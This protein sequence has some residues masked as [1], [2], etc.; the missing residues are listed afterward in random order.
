M[1]GSMYFKNISVVFYS[2]FFLLFL[3]LLILGI[4]NLFAQRKSL[5]LI[6]IKYAAITF[7]VFIIGVWGLVAFV[8]QTLGIGIGGDI[9]T[10]G[11]P[12]SASMSSSLSS[13]YNSERAD[14]TT[15]TVRDTREFNKV[16]Y[17][18]DIK[19]REVED[20]SKKVNSLI[21]VA[22]GR[23]D[24]SSV[25]QEYASFSFV[26]PKSNFESFENDIS[27]LVSQKLYVKHISQQN[28]LNQ[29]QTIESQQKDN[30]TQVS[31]VQKQKTD[32]TASHTKTIA[33]FNFY[34][35]QAKKGL[36]ATN[37]RLAVA[38]DTNEISDL[39]TQRTNFSNTITN[40][41]NNIYS[42]NSNYKMSLDAY[43]A[44]I[45]SLNKTKDSLATQTVDLIDQVETVQGSISIRYVS[46]WQ[47][48]NIYSPISPALVI[49]ILVVVALIYLIV[50][51]IKAARTNPTDPVADQLEVGNR[52]YYLWYIGVVIILFL[53]SAAIGNTYSNYN[54]YNGYIRVPAVPV[55]ARV[56]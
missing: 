25:N 12:T 52:Y 19:T 34:L 6:F 48:V 7:F 41:N 55:N 43:N 39:Y 3:I 9:M 10:P 11:I 22:G 31:D 33:S 14:Y 4:V 18:G 27:A 29:K 28:L 37:A 54:R 56:Y 26:V 23:V 36:A 21:H 16:S 2:S 51:T 47:L 32:L 35:S 24:S 8:S 45:D 40:Y 17:S 20:V 53:L 49:T 15:N 5:G 30:A 13:G 1:N 42:E 46:I 50:K 44:Q 38:T